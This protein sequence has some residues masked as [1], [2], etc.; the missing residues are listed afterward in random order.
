MSGDVD[1]PA[2]A[3]LELGA[4]VQQ[5]V[6]PHSHTEAFEPYALMDFSS[7]LSGALLAG[8]STSTA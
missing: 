2:T 4:T 7:G 1:I 8:C 5:A 3:E 6:K